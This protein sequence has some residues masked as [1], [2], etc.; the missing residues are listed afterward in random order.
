MGLIDCI[1]RHPIHKAKK[2]SAH[3]EKFIVA[4]L[5]L[6][7]TFDNSSILQSIQ[8]APLLHNL[9]QAHNFAP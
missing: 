9:I 3:V 2:V 1:S 4:K 6:I 8:S 5:R 7:S